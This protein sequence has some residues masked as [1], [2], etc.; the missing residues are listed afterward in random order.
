MLQGS[1]EIIT[2]EVSQWGT[3]LG[4]IVSI[5]QEI[6]ENNTNPKILVYS[7]WE[8]SLSLLHNIL[9]SIKIS[10]CVMTRVNNYESVTTFKKD[11]SIHVLLLLLQQGNNGL[12]MSMANH[13]IIMEPILSAS[14]RGVEVWFIAMEAQA[15]SRVQRIGQYLP[16]SVHYV[17]VENTIESKM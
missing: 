11:P 6:I 5:I 14:R 3:K 9:S 13:I 1:E 12:D 17:I 10:A 15:V 7:Q 16:S 2:K 8:D 4:K